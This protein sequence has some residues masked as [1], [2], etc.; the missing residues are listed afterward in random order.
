VLEVRGKDESEPRRLGIGFL[1]RGS[2]TARGRGLSGGFNE[3]G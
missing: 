1:A 2:P 3:V